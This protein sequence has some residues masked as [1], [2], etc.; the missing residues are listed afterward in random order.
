MKEEATG[1]DKVVVFSQFTSMLDLVSRRLHGRLGHVMLD[2]RMPSQQRREA[3]E[4][5]Q[6]R[7]DVNVLL[8]SLK[9]GGTGLNLVCANH[10][11]LIDPWW[12][13]AIEQQCIDR[14][15]RMGQ[16]KPVYVTRLIVRDSAEEQIAR[17]QD[18]KLRMTTGVLDKTALAA[19]TALSVR[20][21]A[22]CFGL[23]PRGLP[24]F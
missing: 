16:T 19:T 10:A 5:F 14:L 11:I 20:E 24:R 21:L 17:L 2:G 9:A 4:A 22:S 3:I 8:V 13:P 1:V 23:G 7:S 15:H 18:T 6:T 12:N